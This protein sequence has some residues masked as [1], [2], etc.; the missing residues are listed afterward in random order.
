MNIIQCISRSKLSA[1][2]SS[3]AFMF[4]SCSLFNTLS[5][6]VLQQAITLIKNGINGKRMHNI[7]TLMS[8][9]TTKATIFKD[10]SYH[11]SVPFTCSLAC[12][13]KLIVCTLPGIPWLVDWTVLLTV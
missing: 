9:L 3:L 2:A 12:T 7:F 11:F 5:T 10:V 6:T 1:K 4:L 13:D 8:V